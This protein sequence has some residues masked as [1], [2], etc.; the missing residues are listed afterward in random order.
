MPRLQWA[1][2]AVVAA[3][4]V[5]QAGA[6][7]C[8]ATGVPPAKPVPSLQNCYFFNS[9]SCCVAGHD[10]VIGEY[11]KALVPDTCVAEY[12]QLARLFCAACSPDQPKVVFSVNGTLELRLCQS[13]AMRL[14]T[15]PN[16]YSS[17][18]LKIKQ[19]DASTFVVLPGIIEPG[20]TKSLVS[21][22]AFVNWNGP[23]NDYPFRPPML[24]DMRFIVAPDGTDCFTDAG[25]AAAVSAAALLLAGLASVSLRRS[26]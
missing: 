23:L 26:G 10:D 9:L 3:V 5:S 19:A 18:G 13:Y 22:E 14:F 15:T 21:V 8:R 6:Q 4:V 20:G 17:C 1:V 25:S 7:V 11:L 24:R 2:V 16:Q 12:P